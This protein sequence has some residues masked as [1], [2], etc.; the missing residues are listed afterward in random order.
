MDLRFARHRHRP[1]RSLHGFWDFVLLGDVDVDQVDSAALTYTDVMPV[2]GCFDASPRYAGRRGVAAYRTVV[3]VQPGQPHQLHFGSVQHWS[4]VLIDHQIVAEQR[5]GYAPFQAT[6]TPRHDHATLTVLVDN[7]FHQRS[8]L[9]F[10]GY[11][12]Y[13]YGGIDREV[14]LHALP[15]TWIKQVH[16]HT[17]DVAARRLRA[18]VQI[19]GQARPDLPLRITWR[20]QVL[21]EGPAQSALELTLP[22]PQDQREGIP[23]AR[24]DDRWSPAQ[25]VLHTLHFQLGDDDWIERVGLRQVAVRAGQLYLNDQPLQLRGVNY[26]LSHPETGSSISADT[27]INDLQLIRDLG[28]N[29]IRIAHY[30]PERRLL[31]LCDE[32]GLLVWAESL[33]WGLRREEL[34]DAQVAAAALRSLDALAQ[35]IASHPCVIIAGYFNE[36]GSA[37]PESRALYAA[38][39]QKLRDLCPNQLISYASNKPDTDLF[40]D[41][42]DVVSLNLYPGWYH[43]SIETM[44][45]ALGKLLDAARQR[46]GAAGKPIILSEFGGE[47]LAGYRDWHDQRWSER[48]QARLFAA[49]WRAAMA[50]PHP[51]AG[52]VVWQ[53]CDVRTSTETRVQMTR[54]RGFNNKGIVD[55]HR[56]PK[57]AYDTLQSLFRA[58][59]QRE[60]TT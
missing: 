57:L 40:L 9:H 39:A 24:V 28:C 47:A 52:F 55:E 49:A 17:L 37:D 54:P 51:L 13:Q 23:E 6:F 10:P 16:V 29:F 3:P 50:G 12:W 15:A 59:A 53:F 32:L 43:D 19:A 11:D 4:R 45:A 14:E 8:E 60:S 46:P 56:M 58:A 35:M 20:D 36:C 18:H 48:Y 44:D 22:Q 42:V 7:R 2:P 5:M 31:D 30:P 26:H 38:M 27:L 25:P 34:Q 33:S 21:Y 41:L 1:V